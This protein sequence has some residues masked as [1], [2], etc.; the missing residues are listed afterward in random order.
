ME[1]LP[2]E[3]WLFIYRYLHKID[4]LYSFT[5]LNYRFQQL[6]EPYQYQIDLN[7]ISLN[8]LKRFVHHVLPIYSDQI[9][10]LS[11]Q[12]IHQINFFNKN[13]I[14]QLIKN[15]ECLTFTIDYD[16]DSEVIDSW[17]QKFSYM[18]QL[19]ELR[20]N[21]S[22]DF[23]KTIDNINTF[24]PASLNNM[25]L[26]S[27]YG[28]QSDHHSIS[29]SNI[30]SLKIHLPNLHGFFNLINNFSRL[31]ELYLSVSDLNFSTR[32]Q[33]LTI[34]NSIVKFHLEFG[35]FKKP[36]LATDFERM[37]NF[38]FKFQNQL[39]S[40]VLIVTSSE[41]EF[42]DLNQ[43]Q[44]LEKSFLHLTSFEYLIHTT[45][46]PSNN[47]YHMEKVPNDTYLVYTTKPH[48]PVSF[49]HQLRNDFNYEFLYHLQQ[50]ELFNVV[51]L[52]FGPGIPLV[53]SRYL[54]IPYKLSNLRYLSYHAWS[55]SNEL[56]FFSKL[57][58]LSPNLS[59][60]E[61]NLIDPLD[62]LDLLKYISYS[63]TKIDHLKC[64][65][66][67]LFHLPFLTKLAQIL[68]HLKHVDLEAAIIDNHNQNDKLQLLKETIVQIRHCFKDIIHLNLCVKIENNERQ[69]MYEQLKLWFYE[70][71][72]NI[73][74]PEDADYRIHFNENTFC[75]WL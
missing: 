48:R 74:Y 61:F 73:P 19:T 34:P 27:S 12:N 45:H 10:S 62:I 54:D 52:T 53:P 3:L 69:E 7:D 36:L 26:L 22:F 11:I 9:R 15:L 2:N 56:E 75:I 42:I 5:H 37:K 28:L 23:L 31:E 47:F 21:G 16:N 8:S 70:Q 43:L 51:S 13:N 49:A 55:Y 14:L 33:N 18:Q 44:L 1:Q 4:I 39:R 66:S 60:L 38:L 57:I 24:A 67:Q 68:P 63:L 32:I 41:Q 20:I 35:R 65:C 58:S 6:I 46:H 25:T 40:L 71:Y 29:S 50:E 30:K 17:L 59:F 72:G 64:R